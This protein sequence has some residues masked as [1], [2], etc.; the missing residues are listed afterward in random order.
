[1]TFCS[2]L[3]YNK[4]CVNFCR[5]AGC[6]DMLK[7][8][9]VANKRRSSL[10]KMFISIR[11]LQL[12]TA[13][14]FLYLLCTNRTNTTWEKRKSDLYTK[15]VILLFWGEFMV[16]IYD[17]SVSNKFP[18]RCDVTTQ[19]IQWRNKLYPL[20]TKWNVLKYKAPLLFHQIDM[21]L[22]PIYLL[23]VVD[24]NWPPNQ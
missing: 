1:M 5:E 17:K 4:V 7:L 18:L 20:L 22:V 15:V 12:H 3:R 24:T 14:G 21:L 9:F 11:T 19:R 6:K 23:Y 8:A 13:T 16:R 10:F 2:S